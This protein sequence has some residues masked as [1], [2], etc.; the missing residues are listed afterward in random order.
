MVSQTT[1]KEYC[2]ELSDHSVNYNGIDLIK[3]ICAV[4]VFIIHITPF[5]AQESD[6]FRYVNFGLQ[7]YI[8]RLAVPFYF[9]ASGFFLFKKMPSEG[10]NASRVKDYCFKI[11]RLLGLW[12]ILLFMGETGHLWYLGATVV[13]VILLSLCFYFKLRFRY[14]C[15]F[16]VLLYIIGLLGDSY[17]GLVSP[18]SDITVFD[19]LFK[20]YSRAFVTTRN[21]V[22]MGF[23]FVLLGASFSRYN[24]SPRP[25]SS[26]TG[27]VLSALLL[28]CEVFLLQYNDVPAGYNMYIF[29]VPATFF[30]FAFACSVRLRDSAIYKHLRNIGSLVYFSHLFIDRSVSLGIGAFRKLFS[31]DA[32]P[33]RFLISLMATLLFATVIELLSQKEKFKWLGL[34]LS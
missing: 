7:H 30:L 32:A 17:Y 5:P 20:A 19:Y 4:M 2:A 8:C 18:L 11:L 15:I 10:I 26:F 31:I 12:S 1:K 21:G 9:A 34:L 13:A 16:A 23:I 33:F 27:F 3:L 25:L 29:L 24:I 14:I 6:F 28:F 22:F